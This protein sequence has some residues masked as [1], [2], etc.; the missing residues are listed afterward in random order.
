VFAELS[1]EDAAS[2]RFGGSAQSPFTG[3]GSKE[4]PWRG[5]V[6]RAHLCLVTAV[7]PNK[8]GMATQRP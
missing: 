8:Q 3:N 6:G 1:H 4:N 2:R 7:S 5:V